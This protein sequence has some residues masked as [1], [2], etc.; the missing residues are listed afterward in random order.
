MTIMR[1]FVKMLGVAGLHQSA[2]QT[3]RSSLLSAQSENTGGFVAATD[4]SPGMAFTAVYQYTLGFLCSYG[5][6]I[7]R[8]TSE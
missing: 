2:V 1:A 5:C 3:L 6:N 4:E 7:S 8:I